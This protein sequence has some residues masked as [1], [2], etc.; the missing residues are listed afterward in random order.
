MFTYFLKVVLS[1]SVHVLDCIEL[2]FSMKAKVVI[3]VSQVW[4]QMSKACDTNQT[5]MVKDKICGPS[6]YLTNAWSH[7]ASM[8]TII[9]TQ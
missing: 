7:E 4:G 6:Y 5:P 2:A 9:V 3:N 8:C 1:F